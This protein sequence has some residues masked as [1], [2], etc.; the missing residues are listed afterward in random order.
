MGLITAKQVIESCKRMLKLTQTNEFD[1]DFNI[2]LEKGYRKLYNLNTYMPFDAYFE[3]SNG[4]VKKPKGY[5]EFKAAAVA[6]NTP[7]IFRSNKYLATT[8]ASTPIEVTYYDYFDS[9]QEIGDYIYFG[10]LTGDATELHL[11]WIGVPVDDECNLTIEEEAEEALKYYMAWKYAEENNGIEVEKKVQYYA[12]MFD[13]ESG[14]LRGHIAARDARQ[15][16][17]QI[18][19]TANGILNFYYY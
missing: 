17:Y 11:W 1:G 2:W 6:A 15:R 12:S 10:S 8:T 9:C 13:R 16:K 18:T 14:I 3:I 5:Y 4:R 7:I 19:S